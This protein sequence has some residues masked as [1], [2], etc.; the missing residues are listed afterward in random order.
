[1]ASPIPGCRRK[2]MGAG[3]T[4]KGETSGKDYVNRFAADPQI[5]PKTLYANL[6]TVTG[7]D[8]IKLSTVIWNPDD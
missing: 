2:I 3:W 7:A 1:M 5:E 8:D 4:R 6:D